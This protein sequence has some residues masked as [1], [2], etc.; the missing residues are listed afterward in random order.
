M[1]VYSVHLKLAIKFLQQVI[2]TSNHAHII[3]IVKDH[4]L[5]TLKLI[6]NSQENVYAM[7]DG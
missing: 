7:M 1:Q 3:V 4:V 2:L 6:A 5:Y